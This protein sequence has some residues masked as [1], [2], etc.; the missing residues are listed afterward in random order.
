MSIV[1]VKKRER[2]VTIDKTGIEDETLSF[3]ATGLLV[4]LLSKPDNWTISYRHL[5]TI[6]KEG[7][8]AIREALKELADAGYLHR[9]KIQGVGGLWRTEQVLYE[10]PHRASLFGAR[11]TAARITDALNEERD[12]E[13]GTT[14]KPSSSSTKTKT[15]FSVVDE[16]E[17]VA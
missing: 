12:N 17:G 16:E 10:T 5:A 14:D 2:F 15:R 13:E 7:A 4:Y 6:K 3:K 8:H 1:R 9:Q 11:I